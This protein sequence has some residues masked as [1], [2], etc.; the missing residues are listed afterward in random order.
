MEDK[1]IFCNNEIV[2]AP[3]GP[4]GIQSCSEPAHV[5]HHCP[6][7]PSVV[8]FKEPDTS[9]FPS[10]CCCPSKQ[11]KDEQQLVLD[12]WRWFRMLHGMEE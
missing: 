4:W 1:C 10:E 5:W 9:K 12:M 8:I 11:E 2:T 3:E 7:H 6:V